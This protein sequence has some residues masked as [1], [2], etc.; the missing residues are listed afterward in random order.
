MNDFELSFAG[1]P[2]EWL[3]RMTKIENHRERGIV[4]TTPGGIYDSCKIDECLKGKNPFGNTFSFVFDSNPSDKNTKLFNE[5][6]CKQPVL[7]K[8]K[9]IKGRRLKK[10][11]V[12]EKPFY[13]KQ[14]RSKHF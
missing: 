6:F 8:I 5:E 2:Q 14:S 13:L 10:G 3:D 1:I 4:I 7:N 9:D 11:T 12:V